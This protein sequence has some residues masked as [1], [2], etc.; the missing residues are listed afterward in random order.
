MPTAPSRHHAY[1][2]IAGL[3]LAAACSESLTPVIATQLP[4]SVTAHL[5]KVS[6]D[7]QVGT[8]DQ[9]LLRPYVVQ[10]LDSLG[11]PLV[12]AVVRGRTIGKWA[13]TVDSVVLTD[14]L[15][16]AQLH[17]VL[18]PQAGIQQTYVRSPAAPPD[19]LVFSDSA[20]AALASHRP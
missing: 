12:S 10:L 7:G 9:S 1:V 6:G 14:T 11:R 4:G 13:G 2:A 16:F 19:T 15:G 18:G 17:R 5:R 8:I 20:S 3:V